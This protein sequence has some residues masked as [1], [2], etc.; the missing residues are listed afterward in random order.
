[1][2]RETASSMGPLGL[3]GAAP[4]A[5]ALA[6]LALA[7]CRN[8][9]DYRRE[10]DET[11]DA[12]LSAY[13][14]KAVGRVEKIEIE[15]P[16][17]TL[18]RRLMIDQGL[19]AKDPASFGIRDL[20]TNL[21]WRVGDRMLP[22]GVDP[23]LSVWKGGTNALEIGL[24]DAVRIAA[25]NSREYRSRKESLYRTA[26]GMDLHDDAFRSIF[27]GHLSSNVGV[28]YDK[29]ERHAVADHAVSHNESATLG[30]SRKFRNGV[31]VTG[32]IMANVAGM[33]TGD[34]RTAWGSSAD[35]SVSIP[36][37]RGSGELVNTESLTQAERSFIYEVRAFEEYKRS[38]ICSIESAY[39]SLVLAKRR[40]QN[41][42]E[43]FR[44]VIRSTRR[45]YRMAEASRTSRADF[46]QAHQSELSSKASWIASCQSYESTMDGFKMRLGLPPDA[47]IEPRESDLEELERYVG[48]VVKYSKAEYDMGRDDENG[49]IV[50][51]APDS[52][53]AGGLKVRTD[54]AI[55]I[56]FSNRLDFATARDKLEDAQ[57]AVLIAEDALRAEVTIGAG[58]GNIADTVGPGS[59]R[60]GVKHGRFHP[61]EWS[62]NPV[63]TID[64]PIER[65]SERNS[66]RGALIAM[67]SE[68][69]SY[70]D[71]EDGL[72]EQIRSDMRSMN[73]TLDNLRI[74][75][76]AMELAE[77]RVRNQ[78]ILQQA[79]RV[80]MT[81]MLEAQDSLVQA[82]NSL[83][84]AMI[85]YKDQ[86]L[87][88]QKDLGILEVSVDGTW[89]ESDLVALGVL[90]PPEGEGGEKTAQPARSEE[91]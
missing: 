85:T 56:A 17:D 74:E 91:G 20:P 64:L 55:E 69:R 26:L 37:L 34:T 63:L 60:A 62:S 81:V 45:S 43:A 68:V 66:Y 88:L 27:S 42:D 23:S 12:Y 16:A 2:R 46:E 84:G 30:V 86:E 44:R 72:K 10:A 54:R 31:R 6:V 48:S 77:R 65:R 13:Q 41:Q 4:L 67:E 58:V 28:N 15:T 1:M 53:D 82:K 9:A 5:V 39:L 35:L 87:Q 78:E 32:S 8:A 21:Y 7:S 38:F 14:R 29:D 49:Q 75:F 70:Q 57:R 89:K 3:C 76:M 25:Y 71:F 18:R 51:D 33:L 59:R 73:Q 40:R 47:R 50:L 83:Y 11:A 61:R 24:V 90:L 52:V 19:L 80:N 79:G 22:G 36:L